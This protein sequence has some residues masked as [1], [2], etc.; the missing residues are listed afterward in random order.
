MDAITPELFATV[1]PLAIK[2]AEDGQQFIFR[3]GRPLSVQE[4]NDARLA[5]VQHPE[6]IM[7]A[8][9]PHVPRPDDGLL[10]HFNEIVKLVTPET[11]GLCLCHGIFIRIDCRDNRQLLVHEC[12]HTSQY[13]RL[14]GIGPFLRQY[15]AECGEY[16]YP[17]APMEQE[18][19][20][21]A[22]RICL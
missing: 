20:E 4:Q 18:A 2:W 1:I 14:G 19:I 13:E 11:T 7:V 8:A 15:L 6:K 12:V 22:R 16:G 9:V 17:E 21:T 3:M 5:G 10:K